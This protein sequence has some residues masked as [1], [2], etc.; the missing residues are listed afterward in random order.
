MKAVFIQNYGSSEQ[1]I[2]S[3]T[4]APEI[5]AD[6]VLVKIHATTVNHLDI[7]K[8]S[9]AMQE[10]MPV[11]FPWIPGH[12]FA[13]VVQA[14]GKNVSTFKKGDK[15][16]GNCPGGSYAEYVAADKDKVVLMPQSLSFNEAACIPH[17]GETAWQAVHTHGRLQKGQ[18]VLIHGGAGGVGAYAVQFAHIAGATVYATA[19]GSDIEFVKSL[20]ADKVIDYKT[21]DF[22]K[23]FKDL[24]LVLALVNNTEEKSYS[25]LKEGGRLV[26]TVYISHEELAKKKNITAIG[27]V[28]KQSGADL[29]KISDLVNA[30]KIKTDIAMT[31]PLSEAQKGW[32]I[33]SGEKDMPK[34]THGKI[35]LE[36]Q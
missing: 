24:D 9:G 29:Q 12:D 20:G 15:V 6:Q 33:L 36:V 34:I 5:N 25:V 10:R 35:V 7:K 32:K 3:E 22:T 17:V 14:T 8:A 13:G 19:A 18:K 21:D 23:E 31:L 2:Y 26:S 16:Y 4:N 1:L 30:G 28:I 11:S 27:M